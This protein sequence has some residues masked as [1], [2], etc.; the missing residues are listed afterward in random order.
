[1]VKTNKD[2]DKKSVCVLIVQ[3]YCRA[4]KYFEIRLV[5][6]QLDYFIATVILTSKIAKTLQTFLRL[7]E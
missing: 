2:V 4:T 3:S 1:M 7:G 5:E 6:F